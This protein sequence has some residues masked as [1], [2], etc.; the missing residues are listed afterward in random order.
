[1]HQLVDQTYISVQNENGYLK[2][3]KLK[4][5]CINHMRI[6]YKELYRRKNE[7]QNRNWIDDQ[8]IILISSSVILL[9]K[10]E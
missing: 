8:K 2:R 1:M 6:F 10:K 5:R 3:E 9:N 4:F 7:F